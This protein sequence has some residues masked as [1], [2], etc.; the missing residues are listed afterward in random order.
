MTADRGPQRNTLGGALGSVAGGG[1][2][3]K[4]WKCSVGGGKAVGVRRTVRASV[5]RFVGGGRR[6]S[7]DTNSDSD[8]RG[9]SGRP[10]LHACGGPRGQPTNQPTNGTT[11][12]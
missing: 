12:R 2:E 1:L 4:G 9:S 7:G 5:S 10:R 11:N 8:G 3:G 6:E